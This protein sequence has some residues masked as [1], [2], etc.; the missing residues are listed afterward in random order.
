MERWQT[1]SVYFFPIPERKYDR[2][3]DV[4]SDLEIASG[5]FAQSLFKM[6]TA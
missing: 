4:L 5:A 1:V 6:E 2:P 3:E